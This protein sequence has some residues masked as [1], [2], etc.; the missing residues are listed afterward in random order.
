MRFPVRSG[1]AGARAGKH[2]GSSAEFLEHREYAPGDDARRID[3]AA[4]A[5]SQSTVIKRF[6]AEE[7]AWVRLVVDASGSMAFGEPTKFTHAQRIAAALGYL[8]LA[9]GE[10]VDSCFAPALAG[11]MATSDVLRGASSRGRLLRGLSG[12]GP[13]GPGRLADSALRFMA[14][15]KTRTAVVVLSDFLEDGVLEALSRLAA[16]GHVLYLV[17]VLAPEEVQPQ[18]FGD[19]LLEDAETG[20]TLP[21]TADEESV[22]RYLQIL[23]ELQ[24]RLR[25]LALA[26]RGWLV[27][28]ASDESLSVLLPRL[29]NGGGR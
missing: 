7:D 12:Q 8:A 15:A 28:T 5:R 19:F 18:L 16:R 22:T 29:V 24:G 4:Y 2:G 21:F 17:Q 9:Q 25:E 1:G 26:S 14:H 6:R 13:R 11:P 3:W 10:R 27:T 23:A 20:D